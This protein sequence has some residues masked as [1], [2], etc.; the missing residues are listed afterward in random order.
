MATGEKVV[1]KLQEDI[2]ADAYDVVH[3]M[4]QRLAHKYHA[5]YGGTYEEWLSEAN[6]IFLQAFET[7]DGQIQLSTWI[8]TKVCWGFRTIVRRKAETLQFTPIMYRIDSIKKQEDDPTP[9]ITVVDER[10]QHIPSLLETIS[11]HVSAIWWI[12]VDPP[13][14][15]WGDLNCDTPEESKD[16]IQWYCRYI[17]KWTPAEIKETFDLLKDIYMGDTD[18]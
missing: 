16:A 6:W 3:K 15:L 10:P 18:D 17:L 1:N 7:Y 12:I 5:I 13:K 11:D 2:I 4:L 9:S 14:E 8:Y